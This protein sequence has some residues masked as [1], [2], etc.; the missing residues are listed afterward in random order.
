M[1]DCYFFKRK[2]WF[3]ESSLDVPF[4]ETQVEIGMKINKKLYSGKSKYQDIEFYDLYYFGKAMVL[5]GVLQ[6][7]EKDEFIYHEMLCQVPMFLHKNPEKVL[8]IGGG[9]GGSLEEVLKHNIK[10]VWMVEID[11]KVVDLS[12]KYLSKISKGSFED[13]RA[14]IISGDGKDFI[15][16]YNNFFDVIILDL[17]DPGGPAENLI[18]SKFYRDIKNA[19]KRE[20]IISMQ[21]GSFTCQ[22]KMVKTIYSRVGKVFPFS[23]I[24]KAVVPSYYAGEY[25]FTL[26]FNINLGKMTYGALKKKYDKLGLRLDYYSPEIHFASTVLPKYLELKG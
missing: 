5:D 12:K 4:D 20:G 2:D 13:E 24:R 16:N 25:S 17:S 14:E 1:K 6:T 23:Q 19:L 21:S 3:F 9:D 8:I 26:A 15:K 10:K 18:S 7:S 11:K 22:P